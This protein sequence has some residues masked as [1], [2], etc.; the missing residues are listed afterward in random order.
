MVKT[1]VLLTTY[2]GSIPSG[3][4]KCSEIIDSDLLPL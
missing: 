4:T 1:V 3:P 2:E